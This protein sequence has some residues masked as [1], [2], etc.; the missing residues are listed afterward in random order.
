MNPQSLCGS[1]RAVAMLQ[2]GGAAMHMRVV[3]V[4]GRLYIS[5]EPIM[6]MYKIGGPGAEKLHANATGCHKLLA[7]C[8]CET[9]GAPPSKR[10]AGR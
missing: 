8:K 9:E 2:P 5:S 7:Y 10:R 6:L 4:V 1:A 3:G